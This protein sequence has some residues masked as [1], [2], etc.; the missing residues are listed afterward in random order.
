M[1]FLA[2]LTAA[3]VMSMGAAGA[4]QHCPAWARSCGKAEAVPVHRAGRSVSTAGLPG[5]LLAAIASV[6]RACP[7]FRVIS[8]HRPNARV[9]GPGRRSLHAVG[10]AA[11]IAGGNYACA[12]RV[13]AG[14]PGGVSTD[15]GRVRH[16]H[17]SYAPGG[18]EW[19]ARFRHYRPARKRRHARLR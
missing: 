7:G 14:F 2:V 8:A 10:R 5:P 15:P 3:F 9:R 12:Y 18:Q 11:D 19:G 13:L 6:Q 17:L 4:D 1:R 16:I